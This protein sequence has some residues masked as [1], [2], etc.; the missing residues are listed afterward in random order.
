MS[1]AKALG[2]TFHLIS[3]TKFPTISA[4]QKKQKPSPIVTALIECKVM[5]PVIVLDE[6]DKVKEQMAFLNLL[7]P[8]QNKEFKDEV[9]GITLDL[10]NVF[11]VCTA[12]DIS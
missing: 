5:N 4:D 8:I 12:N 7:D 1:I 3:L 10:S 6:L 9:L 2:R 11:F